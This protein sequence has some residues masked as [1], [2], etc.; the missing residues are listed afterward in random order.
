E[1]VEPHSIDEAVVEIEA[2]DTIEAG[3][4]G[5]SIRDDLRAATR[6]SASIGVASNRPVAKIAS[7]RAKPGGVIAVAPEDVTTFLPPL[8]LSVM[9]GIGPKTV[10]RLTAAGLLTVADLAG[11]GGAKVHATLG[12]YGEVLRRIASGTYV[13][14]PPTRDGPRSRSID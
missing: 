13:D 6:L 3:R 7:D 9:P 12:A 8:P 1:R 11:A 10:V 2:P 14:S 4:R 5:A